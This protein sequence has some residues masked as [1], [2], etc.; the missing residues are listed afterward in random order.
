MIY[1]YLVRNLNLCITAQ[2]TASRHA[3][4]ALG[5]YWNIFQKQKN[6]SI[7]YEILL[8][9]LQVYEF[10]F[11]WWNTMLNKVVFMNTL[12]FTKCITV[13]QITRHFIQKTSTWYTVRLTAARISRVSNVMLPETSHMNAF[14]E[15]ITYYSIQISNQFT[16]SAN[17]KLTHKGIIPKQFLM[18]IFFHR[19]L[20]NLWRSFFVGCMCVIYIICLLR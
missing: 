2:L 17:V 6:K 19:E 12:L 3:I 1:W 5:Q 8:F 14:R 10:K 13:W 4:R 20:N 11:K 9:Y 16:C 15:R 18:F 7:E